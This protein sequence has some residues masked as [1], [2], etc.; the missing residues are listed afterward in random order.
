MSMADAVLHIFPRVGALV[1]DHR[2]NRLESF[3]AFE[4]A[5]THRARCA[6]SLISRTVVRPIPGGRI[7]ELMTLFESE[8]SRLFLLLV[9]LAR[10]GHFR[11]RATPTR[12]VNRPRCSQP[13]GPAPL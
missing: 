4:A 12:R 7:W 11:V 5:Y 3:H 8:T 13:R 6:A 1:R 2:P 10:P 9:E